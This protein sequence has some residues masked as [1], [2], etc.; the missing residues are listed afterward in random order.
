M[1]RSVTSGANSAKNAQFGSE[2]I[3]VLGIQWGGAAELKYAERTIPFAEGR[4]VS[5]GSISEVVQ[6]DS[7]ASTAS[8]DVTLSDTDGAIK[9][10]LDSTD[11]HKNKVTVYQWFDGL[12]ESDSIV[13]FVGEINS[14]I[15]WSETAQTVSFVVLSQI[16]SLEVGF[17]PEEGQF[18][19]VSPSLIGK[20][21]P[22]AF[23]E[24]VHVPAVKS[25]EKL[26]GST[27]TL[28][29]IPDYTLP[30]KYHHLQDRIQILR[31]GFQYYKE[32]VYFLLQTLPVLS[33]EQEGFLTLLSNP[34][35]D[36]ATAVDYI[37]GFI[38]STAQ[39][40]EDS[41]VDCILTEDAQKQDFEDVNL[42]IT[43]Q[44]KVSDDIA[45]LNNTNSTEFLDAERI[46]ALQETANTAFDAFETLI[47][48]SSVLSSEQKSSMISLVGKAV[49]TAEKQIANAIADEEF[50]EAIEA[51]VTEYVAIVDTAKQV[52][53]LINESIVRI[54][55][56]KDLIHVDIEN[57][58]YAFQ[59]I[60]TILHKIN[61]LY[62]SEYKTRREIFKV[63]AVISQHN[64]I[65]KYQV[66]VIGG[67]RFPQST[68][69]AVTINDMTYFGSFNGK[70]FTAASI[71]PRYSG[72]PVVTSS[73]LI[74][75]FEVADP[76]ID[77]RGHYCLIS[78]PT[79]TSA[80]DYDPNNPFGYRIFQ[81]TNQVGT[82]CTI[83]LAELT[84]TV[85]RHRGPKL[86]LIDELP[87]YLINKLADAN[88]HTVEGKKRILEGA[89]PKY[90]EKELERIKSN[91]D[92]LKE[93][94]EGA[95]DSDRISSINDTIFKNVRE[96]NEKV[97][98]LRYKT[99]EIEKAE[100]KISSEE[101]K[102]FLRL[103]NLKYRLQD[104]DDEDYEIIQ[105]DRFYYV[106]GYDVNYIVASSPTMLPSW[107]Q[108]AAQGQELEQN[109]TVISL[110]NGSRIKAN[111]LPDSGL[112][113]ADVGSAVSLIN[114]DNEKYIVNTLPSTISA[115]YAYRS[116]NGI[117]QLVPVPSR[118]YTKNEADDYGGLTC[119]T[120][121]L[122]KRLQDYPN[123]GWDEGLYVSFA[124][125]VGPNT[126][127]IIEWIAERYT[128]LTID[129]V[130]F[131]AVRTLVDNYPSSFALFNKKDA[132]TLIREIAW[133]ARCSVWVVEGKLYI[134][135]LSVAPTSEAT[136]TESHI[137]PNSLELQH[138]TTEEIVT[139]FTATWKPDYTA[140]DPNKIILRHNVNKYGTKESEY[141]FYIYNI[142]DLVL[143]SATFW[144]I[145]KANTWKIASFQTPLT[146][147]QVQS[148][149][150]I[151]I[152]LTDNPFASSAV[153][154]IVQT[155]SYSPEQNEITFSVWLPV[156]AGEMVPYDFAYP[157]SVEVDRIYPTVSEIAAGNAGSGGSNVPTSIA[158]QIDPNINLID[159]LSLR[160][161]DYGKAFM[162]DAYDSYPTSVIAS[163]SEEDYVPPSP[164]KYTL[165]A[166]DLATTKNTKPD[167]LTPEP[168][169]SS[170]T[171][172]QV[173]LGRVSSVVDA[174]AG[175]YKVRASNNRE[176]EVRQFGGGRDALSANDPVTV[177][178]EGNSLL[179]NEKAPSAA[180][181][182]SHFRIVSEKD[183]H[184]VC[185]VYNP[186]D[187]STED[188]Q[189]VIAKP[190]LLR[191][192]PFDGLT[193]N[194]GGK[195][196][197]YSYSPSGT[198]VDSTNRYRTAQTTV[199]VTNIGGD[200]Y[201][202][203]VQQAQKIVPA[204]YAGDIVAAFRGPTGFSVTIGGE[205][206]PVQWTDLNTGG[207][208]W[209]HS[210]SNDP[211]D[212]D[213]V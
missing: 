25:V 176:Y 85:E 205:A 138:T 202:T 182:I 1:A 193:I 129:S 111:L 178:R 41:Y 59:N 75:S 159:Q 113:Y 74:D 141:D 115:V 153:L 175:V 119:T 17:S 180:N 136:V 28:I 174:D 82:R 196:I 195:S 139:K 57:A 140:Q 63:Q 134:K 137:L 190:Y 110:P 3:C 117:R 2:P 96:Y 186:E 191:R 62:I 65:P 204:Y 56:V 45:A 94:A 120:I 102:N 97:K 86:P 171:K 60:K 181:T 76:T 207:R 33:V 200:N 40:L 49:Q 66:V 198:D 71:Q 42:F 105:T 192:K 154:G 54:E 9:A 185:N 208:M 155:A 103:Q 145:R 135:Y 67:E 91:I 4:I 100:Q 197:T 46:N 24:V 170:E 27:Q 38:A 184:L 35:I 69:I 51:I 26:V 68:P 73:R 157:S 50:A 70:L 165:P 92:K 160:P 37:F 172:V 125:S 164:S 158:F 206:Q 188:E 123:E 183:N 162:S 146:A 213:G 124:S 23:G 128:N 132:L 161:K 58:E 189:V 47:S 29:G 64:L 79:N 44:G 14:P 22:L 156:R 114:G 167:Y 122:K 13:L 130:S 106:T 88:E 152:D 61:K 87:D 177:F 179:I 84:P 89:I 7:N 127:D 149:D 107:F 36:N 133:Q 150:G 112:W 11:V 55:G 90:D 101:F 19:N 98:N 15:V 20:T 53:E 93:I 34:T 5:F 173:F 108:F 121:T 203:S 126:V 80:P 168:A 72:I 209:A 21:W 116:L 32:A 78:V 142:E 169:V 148:L 12:A 201:S 81:V 52:S 211:V 95:V 187:D 39:A 194:Q 166:E 151:T 10:I 212:S 31:E 143:K 43:A 104:Q 147:L 6:L 18:E 109:S 8:V 144:M 16:E 118:Y 30:Y 199:S 131:A 99:E 83:Q 48:N 210:P 77:L 163:L